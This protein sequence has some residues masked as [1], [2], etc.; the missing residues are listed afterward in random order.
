M[1]YEAFYIGKHRKLRSLMLYG[2]RKGEDNLIR[3][4]FRKKNK[5]HH[6]RKKKQTKSPILKSD[7]LSLHKSIGNL[8]FRKIS[9]GTAV[10]I[11]LKA[12][13]NPETNI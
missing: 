7:I 12:I 2:I 5:K 13:R 10:L 11:M 1:K 6:W 8:S 3:L 4:A 9:K